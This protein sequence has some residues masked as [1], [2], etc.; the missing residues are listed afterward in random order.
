MQGGPCIIKHFEVS[1][2]RWF[3]L[4]EILKDAASI[5]DMEAKVVGMKYGHFLVQQRR[6]ALSPPLP[7][8]PRM[9]DFIGNPSK[10][11]C[12]CKGRPA[13][14]VN[15]SL[16]KTCPARLD[17]KRKES[18]WKERQVEKRAEQRRRASTAKKQIK[19]ITK[20][21]LSQAILLE[22]LYASER[23]QSFYFAYRECDYCG[24]RDRALRTSGCYDCEAADK[25]LRNAAKR[26]ECPEL[27]EADNRKA[28]LIYRRCREMKREAGY[29]AYHVDHI[30][31]LSKGGSHHPDN[32]QILTA[33]ENLSKG[34]K[35]Q[36]FK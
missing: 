14:E 36:D 27:S 1:R 32:L 21:W 3:D 10:C 29:I 13:V 25:A 33:A 15:W 8:E 6:E 28:V 23:R 22:K 26:G 35:I 31:P 9:D 11:K 16:Y 17:R 7:D 18:K 34:A 12:G 5:A 24:G 19:A 2:N 30:F 4:S 20:S